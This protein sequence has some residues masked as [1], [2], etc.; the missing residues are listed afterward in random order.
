MEE[1]RSINW[2]VLSGFIIKI[3]AIVA[4]TIDHI[5]AMLEMY[6]VVDVIVSDVFR[7]I[8]RLAMPLFCFLLAEGIFHTKKPGQYFLRLGIMGTAIT[9]AMVTVEYAPFFEG[10]SL[11][12][13]GNIFVDLLLGAIAIYLLSNKKWYIKI[14]AIVPVAISIMSFV[15]VSIEEGQN[16][17]IHWFPFFLRMQY[18]CYSMALILLFYLMRYPT[19]WF[20]QTYS[21]NSG[22][23]VEALEGTNVERYALNI[24]S[25]LALV[26]TTMGFYLIAL[27]TPGVYVF[28]DWRIQPF[29]M[30][31]GAFLLIYSGQRGYNAKWFKYG[32]YLYYPL[33]L[34]LIY[35]IGMLIF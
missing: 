6:G 25:T 16:I 5:G 32:C 29:A 4:M 27:A 15:V 1:K 34:I 26:V 2:A 33:H 21:N 10:V 14:L 35:V 11:R 7:Y 17:L 31:A 23:P 19:K 20:L 13:D 22:I 18:H 9:I 28:W 24:F 8:G 12:N 30:V 3:I